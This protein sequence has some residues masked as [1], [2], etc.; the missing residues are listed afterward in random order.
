MRPKTGG[1]GGN[2]IRILPAIDCPQVSDRDELAKPCEP[3]VE[4]ANKRKETTNSIKLS[5]NY[6]LETARAL[7]SAYFNADELY[8]YYGV[9]L[10]A[11][12]SV[13][14]TITFE[15]NA[16]DY[17]DAFMAVIYRFKRGKVGN[18]ANYLYA[19]ARK[20]TLE[21]VRRTNMPRFSGWLTE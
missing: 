3:T 4:V 15:E 20:A 14:D 16:E 8:K 5:N 17:I 11:K 7:K 9:L 1:N 2:I 10:R 6:V 13:S 21:I 19:S 12:A 18:L